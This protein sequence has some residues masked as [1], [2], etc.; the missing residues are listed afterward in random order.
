M[1]AQS[2]RALSDEHREKHD[3][4]SDEDIPMVI[5]SAYG[6]LTDLHDTAVPTEGLD[7]PDV[8]SSADEG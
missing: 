6:S 2:A 5:N 1:E 3:V 4:D 8:D 7:D